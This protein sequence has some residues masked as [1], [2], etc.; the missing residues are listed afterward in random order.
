MTAPIVHWGSLL[1]ASLSGRPPRIAPR[2]AP[3]GAG[4]FKHHDWSAFVARFAR[5]GRVDYRNFRRVRRLLE[6]YLS[7]VSDARPDEFDYADE[8]LAFYLNAFNAITIYQV[9]QHYPVA[10]IRDTPAAFARPFPV[11]PENLSLHELYHARIRAFGDPRVHAA[12][13]PAAWSAPRLRAYSANG[14]QQELDEQMRELLADPSRGLRA[15]PHARTIALDRMF[16]WFAGDFAAPA[17]MPSV[18]MTMRGLLQP[19]IGVPFLGRYLPERM[20]ALLAETGGAIEWL[21][22]DWRLNDFGE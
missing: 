7:R 11:G 9:L 5:E 22:Y 6:E 18:G 20:D 3:V 1:L 12:V 19:T 10:S 2:G 17:R 13:V 16:R 14:L 4:K 21:T 15:A 8:Q